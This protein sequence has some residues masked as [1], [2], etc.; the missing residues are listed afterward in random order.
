MSILQ[1]QQ[2]GRGHGQRFGAPARLQQMVFRS[3]RCVIYEREKL[4]CVRARRIAHAGGRAQRRAGGHCSG[5][6]ERAQL[7]GVRR[8]AC[9]K[10]PRNRTRDGPHADAS[11]AANGFNSLRY[12]T[13]FVAPEKQIKQMQTLSTRKL[14]KVVLDIDKTSTAVRPLGTHV[15]FSVPEDRRGRRVQMLFSQFTGSMRIL[16]YNVALSPG[17]A[18]NDVVTIPCRAYKAFITAVGERVRGRAAAAIRAGGGRGRRRQRRRLRRAGAGAPINQ[19]GPD[20]QA[21]RAGARPPRPS[22]QRAIVVVGH[23]GDRPLSGTR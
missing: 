5:R 10:R 1:Q 8:A 4:R 15:A 3:R 22:A 18:Y 6:A 17:Q 20:A 12:F 9:G 13:G 23:L 2:G 11:P 7:G 14:P 21:A 19:R 16:N